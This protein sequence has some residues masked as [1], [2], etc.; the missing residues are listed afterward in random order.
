MTMLAEP[1]SL[2]FMTDQQLAGMLEDGGDFEAIA[3]ECD[4]RDRAAKA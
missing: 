4:R 1:P 3:A 2:R